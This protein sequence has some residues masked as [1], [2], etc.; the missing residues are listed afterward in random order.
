[1]LEVPDAVVERWVVQ[2]GF[3]EAVLLETLALSVLNYDSAVAA[4]AS[5]VVSA[6]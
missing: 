3:A 5:R 1:M 4:A 2:G 6:A